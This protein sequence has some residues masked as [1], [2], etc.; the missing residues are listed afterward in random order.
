MAIKVLIKRRFKEGYFN[1]INNMIKQVRYGAMNQKGYIGSE[2]MWDHEDP[3]RVVI[4][5]NWRD[6]ESWDAWRENPQ[7][8]AKEKEFEACLDGKTEYEIFDLGI[9][10][11]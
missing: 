3:F 5:S 4:A 11:H 8:Q 6:K 2:T 9:Y 7:R 10:P 1:E